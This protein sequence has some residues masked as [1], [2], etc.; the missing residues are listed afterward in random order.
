LLEKKKI[1]VKTNLE[2]CA[3]T[4]APTKAKMLINNLLSNAIKYS[5]QNTTIIITSNAESFTIEDEGIGIEEEKL[6][7]IFER[8][9]RANSYAGGFG[10]GLNIVD[11]IVKEYGYSIDVQSKKNKGTK[12]TL[13]FR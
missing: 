6:Q 1:K 12:I 10:V 5:K 9:I 3:I 4:I 8:F 2:R 7:I 11:S 13:Y